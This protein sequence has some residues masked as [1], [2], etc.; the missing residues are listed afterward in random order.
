MTR[1][2]APRNSRIHGTAHGTKNPSRSGH[3]WP[4]GIG[5]DPASGSP[6]GSG[7]L[8][9]YKKRKYITPGAPLDISARRLTLLAAAFTLDQLADFLEVSRKTLDRRLAANPALLAAYKKGK[10]M[11]VG[12]AAGKVIQAIRAGNLAACFFYLKT[13]GGWRERA[14]ITSGDKPI[15]PTIPTRVRVEFVEPPAR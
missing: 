13:Q 4:G 2:A 3:E 15:A 8:S 6:N 14:D 12:G 1:H 10:A 7:L 11:T 5:G 9:A